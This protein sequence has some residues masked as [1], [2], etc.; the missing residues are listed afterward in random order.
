MIAGMPKYSFAWGMIG[1][2]SHFV[3]FRRRQ[4]G[5]S[6]PVPFGGITHSWGKNGRTMRGQNVSAGLAQPATIWRILLSA[7]GA[8]ADLSTG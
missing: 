8:F 4:H 5:T 2:N 6:V 3:G 1:T 7:R